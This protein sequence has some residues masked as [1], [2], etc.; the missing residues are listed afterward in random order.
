MS[1]SVAVDF[2]LAVTMHLTAFIGLDSM[3][4]VVSEQTVRGF[5]RPQNECWCPTCR[6]SEQAAST[7]SGL[8][9]TIAPQGSCWPA[10]NGS[11]FKLRFEEARSDSKHPTC[12]PSGIHPSLT[13]VSCDCSAS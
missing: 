12:C 10:S 9:E 11:Y 7:Y 6:G 4:P 13:W 3:R 2:E 1:F 8:D 5:T